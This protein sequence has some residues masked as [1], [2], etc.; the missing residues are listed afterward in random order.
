MRRLGLTL[1]CFAT[2]FALG[3]SPRS[4]AGIITFG[5][6]SNTFGIEFVEIGSP[7]NSADTT[8][9]P[10][11][12]GAVPYT[13]DIAKFEISR[14][15]IIKANNVGGLGIT[16]DSMSFVTGGARADMPATGVSWFEAAKFVNWLNTS[17][18]YQAAYNFDSSGNFQLWDVGNSWTDSVRGTNRFRHK[19][20]HFW[21]PSVD[22]WYKA[23]YY[24]PVSDTWFNYPSSDGSVPTAVTSGTDDKTAVYNQSFSQG[25]ADITLAGGLSPF[26]V[27][28]LGGNVWEWEESAFDVVNDNPGEFRGIRGGFW[29]DSSG[30]LSS[31]VRPGAGSALE[32]SYIGF[33]VASLHASSSAVPE[34]AS[35]AV[36]ALLGAGALVWGK[37]RR[38]KQ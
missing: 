10:N 18:G 2:T 3:S 34:P 17:K 27:M 29:A 7:G 19:D 6:G 1:A 23:A 8:G 20:A 36:W 30:G 25:P 32:S 38:K 31:S 33:R 28:G 35:V 5:S 22:E 9:S 15:M 16:L 24:N 37:K 4:L 12:A 13:F 21:L 11:P 26:G 14:D